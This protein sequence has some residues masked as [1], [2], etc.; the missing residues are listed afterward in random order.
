MERRMNGILQ[1]KVI[2]ITGGASGLGRILTEEAVKNSA[3]VF[4]TYNSSQENADLLMNQYKGKA[5]GFKADASDYNLAQ[6]AIKT[7]LEKYS[8]IDVLINNAASVKD[9]S[10]VKHDID[11][12]DYTM[13]NVLYPVFNYCKAVSDIF[14]SRKSGKI[15]NI[16]SIN[17]M[18]GREGSVAYCTAK[19]GIEG[20]T[21]TIAKELGR[22][23]INC[24][25][26]APGYIDTDG[27][28]NTSEL[29]KKLVLDE[30]SIKNLMQPTDVANLILFLASDKANSITGQVYKIDCG[31][32][33]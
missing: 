22:Y 25:V 10:L 18:R 20:F 8:K 28:Q 5:Y 4:F 24:N 31:Q 2:F 1:D 11:K 14:I 32:Y 12:F 17:G 15:I 19:A 9:S 33:I 3:K 23:N 29:I 27:Q 16:G 21:K 6:K 30:C 7:C 26:V 13:K